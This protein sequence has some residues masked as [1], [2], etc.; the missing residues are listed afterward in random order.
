MRDLSPDDAFFQNLAAAGINAENAAAPPEL[1][2]RLVSALTA[3]ADEDL[4]MAL[5]AEHPELPAPARLKSRIYSAMMEAQSTQGLLLSLAKCEDHGRQ[6]C[7]FESLVQIAPVGQAAQ[8]INYCR[9][10]HARVLAEHFESAP[11]YW[12]GCPYVSFQ[13]R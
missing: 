9:I 1:K 5:G 3:V 10:C 6:L 2:D 13:N 8:S 12:H 4:F 7:V 11:I